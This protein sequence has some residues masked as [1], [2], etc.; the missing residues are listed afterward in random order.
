MKSDSSSAVFCKIYAKYLDIL[1]NNAEVESD[2]IRRNIQFLYYALLIRN[3]LYLLKLSAG[4]ERIL[5]ILH[6]QKSPIL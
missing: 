2:L 3:N 6:T 4:T 1:Q 5:L